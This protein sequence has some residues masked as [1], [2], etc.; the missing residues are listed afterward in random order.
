LVPT[1]H[2]TDAVTRSTSAGTSTGPGRASIL[3]ASARVSASRSSIS[4]S[5]LCALRLIDAHASFCLSVTGP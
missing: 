2:D 4:D 5:R 3:P 1:I